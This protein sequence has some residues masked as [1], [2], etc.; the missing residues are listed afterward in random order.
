ML[1]MKVKQTIIKYSIVARDAEG[2]CQIDTG[3]SVLLVPPS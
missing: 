3:G 1:L 2:G